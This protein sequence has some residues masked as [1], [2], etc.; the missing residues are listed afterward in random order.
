MSKKNFRPEPEMVTE[1]EETVAVETP[2]VEEPVVVP[3][4]PV[5]GAVV[6]D[7]LNVRK[8]PNISAEVLLKINRGTKVKIDTEKST[9]EWYKVV[10]KGVDGYCMKKFIEL[11]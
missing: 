1:V 3:A 4:E 7:K 8:K 11:S 2:V 5:F 10:T 9:K 6:C